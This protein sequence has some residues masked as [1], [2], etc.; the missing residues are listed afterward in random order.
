MSVKAHRGKPSDSQ[1]YQC[2][3][4]SQVQR[5]WMSLADNTTFLSFLTRI[6]QLLTLRYGNSAVHINH[7]RLLKVCALLQIFYWLRNYIGKQTQSHIQELII[8]EVLQT[9][10]NSEYFFHLQHILHNKSIMLLSVISQW[11]IDEHAENKEN[12]T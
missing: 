1:N 6:F 10:M 11:S 7:M 8:A 4:C 3:Q 2:R 5:C 9:F 12:E